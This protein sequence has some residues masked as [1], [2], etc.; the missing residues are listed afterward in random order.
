MPAVTPLPTQQDVR[1]LVEGLLGRHVDAFGAHDGVD[2]K[3][4]RENLVGTYVS[5]DGHDSALIMADVA[6]SAR[7]GAALGLAPKSAADD[8]VHQGILPVQ[9]GEP[10]A[11]RL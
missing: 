8:A 5:D 10:P 9:L 7:V 11:D 1:E 2:L 3:R 4:N 6:C